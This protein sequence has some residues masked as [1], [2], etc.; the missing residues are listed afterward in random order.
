[1][2]D[3]MSQLPR[4]LR[5]GA[6]EALPVPVTLDTNMC[7]CSDVLMANTRSQ[8][9]ET[10]EPRKLSSASC[11]DTALGT[12]PV[13]RQRTRRGSVVRPPGESPCR[14]TMSPDERTRSRDDRSGYRPGASGT[15]RASQSSRAGSVS[16][17]R[18]QA[19]SRTRSKSVA[20][21]RICLAAVT[22]GLLVA[23]ALPWGGTGGRPL[24]T[25]GPA[26]AGS[27]LSPHEVYIVQP[28]DTLWGIARAL[29]P[30]GD[31]RPIVAK[32]ASEVGSD[33]LVPGEHLVLP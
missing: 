17:H 27:A 26:L 13:M 16:A 18:G 1:M 23:L 25:P 20:R 30:N 31:P 28:G 10:C 12:V 3:H 24:A 2:K 19:G 11:G 29:S 33:S 8:I 5:P 9:W 4:R 7:S 22:I 32:L 14:Q 6:G 21:S 15:G